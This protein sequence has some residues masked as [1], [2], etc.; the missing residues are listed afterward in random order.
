MISNHRPQDNMIIYGRNPILDAIKEGKAF[1]KIFVRDNLTGEFEMEVRKLCKERGISLKKVPLAKLDRL[2]RRA[3]H[4]GAV[5]VGSIV[6]YQSI[7]LIIPHLYEQGKEPLFILIDNVQDVRNIG[8]IARSSEVLGAQALIISGKQSGMI[9]SESMKTSAGALSRLLVCREKNT[10]DTIKQLQS[11]GIKV[12]ATS[13]ES[14]KAISSLD[15]TSPVCICLGSEG[16]GLHRT[17]VSACDQV[18]Y[19]EQSGQTDSL[20]VSVAA[21][22]MLYE[23]NRQIS[24]V[25]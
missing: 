24:K 15:L 22:I 13:V 9:T 20:N 7:D 16:T 12:V 3:N 23:A 21:G 14:G 17:V 4:Q 8:A 2:C 1:E 18:G 5:G 6:S 25:Q 11:Y 10:I 19:I